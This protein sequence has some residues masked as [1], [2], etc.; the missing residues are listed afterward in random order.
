MTLSFLGKSHGYVVVGLIQVAIG[1]LMAW[2]KPGSLTGFAT[3]LSA[4]N[5]PLYGGGAFAKWADSKNGSTP[6]SQPPVPS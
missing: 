2:F 4:I 5:V 3:V 1:T 6:S